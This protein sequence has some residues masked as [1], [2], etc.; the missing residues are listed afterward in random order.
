MCETQESAAELSLDST[1]L[2]QNCV[3]LSYVQQNWVQAKL[4]QVKSVWGWTIPVRS[5]LKQKYPSWN[6]RSKSRRIRNQV[7]PSTTACN[8][9]VSSD[10]V[11]SNSRT[12]SLSSFVLFF[13][14]KQRLNRHFLNK[15]KVEKFNL[16]VKVVINGKVLTFKVTWFLCQ[17][18]FECF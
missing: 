13:S 3:G 1:K 4:C 2:S 18:L 17:K 9:C 10:V 8:N 7:A 11:V 5:K 6:M 15:I 14:F 12:V 16:L